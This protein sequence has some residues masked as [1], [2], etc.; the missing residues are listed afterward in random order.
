MQRVQNQV[1]KLIG[2][3]AKLFTAKMKE[4]S[5]F[6]TIECCV[7]AVVYDCLVEPAIFDY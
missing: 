2:S 7:Y 6:S 5:K 4:Q 3:F 1:V